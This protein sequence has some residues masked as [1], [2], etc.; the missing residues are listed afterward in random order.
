MIWIYLVCLKDILATKLVLD[1]PPRF[2][3]TDEIVSPGVQVETSY[4]QL[5]QSTEAVSYAQLDTD[6]STKTDRAY[7]QLAESGEK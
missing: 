4:A 3:V 1:I 5:E 2:Y 6:Y 7:A